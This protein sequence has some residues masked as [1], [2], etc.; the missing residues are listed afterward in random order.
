MPFRLQAHD[1]SLTAAMRRLASGELSAALA[2]L[3]ADGPPGAGSVHDIRKRIKKLRGLLRLLRPG[4]Q[5]YTDENA[6]LRQ[7]AQGLSSLRDSAVRLAT[8]DTLAPKPS[9]PFEALRNRLADEAA[10]AQPEPGSVAE[11]RALLAAVQSR[12]PSWRLAGTDRA[13]LTEGLART[14]SRARKTMLAARSDPSIEAIHEWRKRAKDFWYQARLFS[15]V[16]PEAITPLATA[17][18]EL[19]EELGRH[20]D[21]AVLADYVANLPQESAAAKAAAPLL[22]LVQEAQNSIE[23]RAFPEGARLFAGNPE[24]MAKLWVEWWQEWHV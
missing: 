8:F 9:R 20:H 6:A 14:R 5:A 10:L 4:L 15:P 18:A 24:A 13:I 21:L 22:P 23:H 16:W 7:A 17:A 3:P 12:V 11:T 2:Q 1:A 19:T